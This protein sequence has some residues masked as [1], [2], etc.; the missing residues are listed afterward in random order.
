MA[1]SKGA[2]IFISARHP[3][4]RSRDHRISNAAARPLIE[5]IRVYLAAE[6]V[7][8][9]SQDL[10]GAGLVA[11]EAIQHS[12][13]EFFLELG[14]GFLEQD[15]AVDHQSDQRFQFFSHDF[16]LHVEGPGAGPFPWAQSSEWP[17][18]R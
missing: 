10:C 15:A 14:Y 1:D 12:L 8:M 7:A 13:D 6:R 11:I 4:E 2:A 5:L 3:P 9:D 17:V 18:M 16:T